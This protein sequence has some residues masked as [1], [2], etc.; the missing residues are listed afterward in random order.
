MKKFTFAF[1]SLL[2]FTLLFS[3]EK[4]TKEEEV[5]DA[6][7]TLVKP[8]ENEVFQAGDTV[9]IEGVANS[10]TDLHGYNV[11]LYNMKTQMNVLNQ[12]YHVHGKSLPFSEKWINTVSDTTEFKLTIQVAIDHEGTLQSKERK[13]I[14]LP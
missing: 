9:F 4:E 6:V 3:C 8:L 1:A 12:G 2:L 10:D 5:K 14:C 13:I 7:V 11:I